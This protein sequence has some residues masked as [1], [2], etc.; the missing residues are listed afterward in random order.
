MSKELFISRN[1]IK[2]QYFP[3]L[4]QEQHIYMYKYEFHAAMQEVSV[5][6][7]VSWYSGQYPEPYIEIVFC[8]WIAII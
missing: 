6:V 5:S 4:C 7:V 1:S 8:S 2:P 3:A